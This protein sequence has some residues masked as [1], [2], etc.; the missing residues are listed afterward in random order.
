MAQEGMVLVQLDD[1]NLAM[2]SVYGPV[3]KQYYGYRKHGDQ[4]YVWNKDAVAFERSGEALRLAEPLPESPPAP[5]VESPTAD[6]S[7]AADLTALWG[8]DEP[9]ADKLRDAGLTTFAAVSAADVQ[10]L[11]D[12]LEVSETVAKRIKAEAG[13]VAS[14]LE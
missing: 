5:P 6:T 11:V 13:K 14:G 8:V 4:F 12:L 9:R 7:A 3:T 2:H 1:R 10:Q